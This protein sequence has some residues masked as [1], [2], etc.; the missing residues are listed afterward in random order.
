[1]SSKNPLD[2]FRETLLRIGNIRP[3]PVVSLRGFLE[4]LNSE[5]GSWVFRASYQA[6]KVEMDIKDPQF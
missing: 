6:L 3:I 2:I 5:L 4:V 1:M